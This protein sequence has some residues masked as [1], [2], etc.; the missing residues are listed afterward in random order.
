MGNVS[1]N[2]TNVPIVVNI[3]YSKLEKLIKKLLKMDM[4]IETI[5]KVTDITKDEFNK[6]KKDV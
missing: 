6:L 2:K 5:S 4:D 3:K 1:S